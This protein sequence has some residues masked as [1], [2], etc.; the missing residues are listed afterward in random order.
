MRRRRY[1]SLIARLSGEAQLVGA[2]N[3]HQAAELIQD[4]LIEQ[5]RNIPRFQNHR[6]N[7]ANKLYTLALHFISCA[8]WQ[9]RVYRS[10]PASLRS[11][12]GDKNTQYFA[13]ST[14]ESANRRFEAHTKKVNRRSP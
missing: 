5:I 8:G 11:A 14:G 1:D 12:V 4:S 10:A 7:C 3:G 13:L 6:G 2:T 9:V